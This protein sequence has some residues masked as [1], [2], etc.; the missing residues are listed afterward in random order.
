MTLRLKK[1]KPNGLFAIR[2]T[3]VEECIKKNEVLHLL[4]GDEKM[5]MDPDSL[6]TKKLGRSPWMTDESGD[7]YIIDYRWEPNLV[8]N[9]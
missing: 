2:N 4:Y 9:D 6:K 1:V 8:P 3:M 7:F 5:T